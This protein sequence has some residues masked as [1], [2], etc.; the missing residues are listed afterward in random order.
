[1][2]LPIAAEKFHDRDPSQRIRECPDVVVNDAIEIG[3]TS[4]TEIG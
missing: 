1:M 4:Q 3:P 2:P